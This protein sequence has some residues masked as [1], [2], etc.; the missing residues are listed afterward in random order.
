MNT[1]DKIDLFIRENGK[2]TRDALN[3]ALTRLELCEKDKIFWKEEALENDTNGNAQI[4][5][6]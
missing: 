5:L 3:I 1:T 6:I 2:N 4:K